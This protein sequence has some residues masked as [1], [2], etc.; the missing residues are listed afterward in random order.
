M[1]FFKR[2]YVFWFFGALLIL[3]PLLYNIYNGVKRENALKNSMI[4]V[5]EIDS[6]EHTRGATYVY[7]QYLFDG[8]IVHNSFGIYDRQVLDSLRINTRV[9][10]KVSKTYPDKYIQYIGVYR[11]PDDDTN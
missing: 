7:V 9:N 8:R 3:I 11:V 10:L 2:K 6:I 1:V 4:L 5:G